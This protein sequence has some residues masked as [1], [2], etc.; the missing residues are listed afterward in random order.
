[1]V[2]EL[3]RRGRGRRAPPPHFD[4]VENT[5]IEKVESNCRRLEQ[6]GAD[7]V[8]EVKPSEVWMVDEYYCTAPNREY[9]TSTAGYR[10]RGAFRKATGRG[11]SSLTIPWLATCQFIKYPD[12]L[13][14]ID[15]YLGAKA[16][17]YFV[18]WQ[19][20]KRTQREETFK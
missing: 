19:V 6:F 11:T 4:S 12:T 2:S 10:R 18:D 15:T 14:L 17:G 1:M 3:K 8:S 16:S 5:D 9:G 20:Q 13:A 7:T